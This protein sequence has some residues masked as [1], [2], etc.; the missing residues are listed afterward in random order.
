MLRERGGRQRS[1]PLARLDQQMTAWP[2]PAGRSSRYPAQHVKPVRPAIERD[3]G[4]VNAGLGRQQRHLAG[5]HVRHVRDH[6][7]DQAAQRPRQRL[8]QITQVD[9]PAARQVAGRA[10]RG[11]GIDVDGV[12]LRQRHG[13]GQR[14]SHGSAAAAKVEH[15]RARRRQRR[16]LRDQELGADPGYEHAGLDRD[17]Q[18]AELRPPEHVLERQPGL[19][20]ADHGVKLDLVLRRLVQQPCLVLREHAS[21]RSEPG[22]GASAHGRQ[23]AAAWVTW[24]ISTIVVTWPTPPGTGVSAAAALAPAMSTSPTSFPPGP[25]LVPTSI[26]TAP[27]LMYSAPIKPARPAATTSTSACAHTSASPIVR[28]WHRVTVAFSA[29]RS[30]ATGLPTTTD[31]PTTTALAPSSGTF[32]LRRISSTAAAVAGANAGSPAASRPR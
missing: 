5:R 16:R 23:R 31:R 11:Y 28:E 19:P 2:E 24:R 29:S 30:S 32:S 13:I 22:H 1:L 3:P 25:G 27:A 14:G 6:D 4:L 18:A 8:V 20:L 12:Q 17:P 10:G 26:T 9:G 7:V 15:D 21:R